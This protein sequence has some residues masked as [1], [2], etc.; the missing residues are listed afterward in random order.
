MSSELYGEKGMERGTGRYQIIDI[1][2][3]DMLKDD[4]WMTFA[5]KSKN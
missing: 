3:L 2:K 5:L 1:I 4:L